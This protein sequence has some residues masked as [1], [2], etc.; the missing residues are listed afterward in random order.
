[1]VSRKGLSGHSC[2]G[3]SPRLRE[4]IFGGPDIFIFVHCDLVLFDGLLSSVERDGKAVELIK[5]SI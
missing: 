3:M 4:Y 1:M 2:E 5:V